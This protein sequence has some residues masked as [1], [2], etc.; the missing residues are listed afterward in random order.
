MTEAEIAAFK[1]H[2]V[3]VSRVCEAARAGSPALDADIA[4]L[5]LVHGRG[6]GV[7]PSWGDRESIPPFTTVM[8]AADMIRP[9]MLLFGIDPIASST[10][11]IGWE[12]WC[13]SSPKARSKFEAK[14]ATPPLAMCAAFVLARPFYHRELDDNWWDAEERQDSAA[15]R[16]H[17]RLIA[18]HGHS[19]DLA[20]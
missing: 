14:G 2:A 16:L 13:G 3:R 4:R 1:R 20:A 5:L 12:C 11:R 8:D 15:A 7:R 19:P 10:N 18:Q 9:V 17:E 6:F